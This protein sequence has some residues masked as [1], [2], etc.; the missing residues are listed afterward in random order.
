MFSRSLIL[1][2]LNGKLNGLFKLR[3]K[4]LK[5]YFFPDRLVSV[6]SGWHF[7]HCPGNDAA[8]L[9]HDAL[10]IDLLMQNDGVANNCFVWNDNMSK[11][12]GER[13]GFNTKVRK[14]QLCDCRFCD[15]L[16]LQRREKNI[17]D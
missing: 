16:P 4:Y 3:S 5:N 8:S 7:E 13:Y 15:C 11:E 14:S 6:G 12:M 10:W 2:S 17:S 9:S 1:T